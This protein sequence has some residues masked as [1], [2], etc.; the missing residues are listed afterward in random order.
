MCETDMVFPHVWPPDREKRA[1]G[2][3]IKPGWGHVTGEGVLRRAT[4]SPTWSWRMPRV[5]RP[6]AGE[7]RSSSMESEGFF[8]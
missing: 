8:E 4:G 7:E 6:E 5:N 3:R 2:A 1:I